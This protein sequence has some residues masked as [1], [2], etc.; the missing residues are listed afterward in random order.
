MTKT[1][2]FNFEYELPSGTIITVHANHTPGLPE[3]MPSLD[4]AGSPAYEGEMEIAGCEFHG[5]EIDLGGLWIRYRHYYIPLSTDI[6][7]KAW[8]ALEN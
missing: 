6:L 4:H 1:T 8:K 2:R 3:R 5:E 7:E